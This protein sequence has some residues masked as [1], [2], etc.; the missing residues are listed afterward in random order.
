V[1]GSLS[2][3]A[4]PAAQAVHLADRA[5]EYCPVLH[6]MHEAEPKLIWNDPAAQLMQL[7][8]SLLPSVLT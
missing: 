5:A 8:T 3:S 6:A 7:A 2:K 4:Q 1:L